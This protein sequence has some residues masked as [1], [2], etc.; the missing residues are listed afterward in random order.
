MLGLGTNVFTG[1]PVRP[2]KIRDA[3]YSAANDA[4]KRLGTFI[5]VPNPTI[6]A[7]AADGNCTEDS[8]QT[9]S[10]P[11]GGTWSY[12]NNRTVYPPQ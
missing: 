7:V 9:N 4:Y 2:M 5:T 6:L 12:Y 10:I 1:Q 3:W 11:T 8:L